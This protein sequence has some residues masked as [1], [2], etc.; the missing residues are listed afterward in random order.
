MRFAVQKWRPY[1]IENNVVNDYVVHF[2]ET[3]AL[4]ACMRERMRNTSKDAVPHL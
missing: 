1:V 3:D 2:L 4:T